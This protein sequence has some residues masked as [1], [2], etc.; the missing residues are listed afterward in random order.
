MR[1]VQTTPPLSEYICFTTLHSSYINCSTSLKGEFRP[2]T[3]C[4]YM[5]ALYTICSPWA[6]MGFVE[7]HGTYA[8]RFFRQLQTWVWHGLDTMLLFLPLFICLPAHSAWPHLLLISSMETSPN[9]EAF[10]RL[11][12]CFFHSLYAHWHILAGC[13]TWP[14]SDQSLF[15]CIFLSLSHSWVMSYTQVLGACGGESKMSK[16]ISI[17]PSP[18]PLKHGNQHWI[19]QQT[20]L[21]FLPRL[22]M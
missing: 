19:I 20:M 1:G 13:S 22:Q 5:A 21:P 10:R 2:H 11:C 17:T 8:P 14:A 15:W 6:H 18:S 4:A 7:T 16:H 12:F 9:L 3:S